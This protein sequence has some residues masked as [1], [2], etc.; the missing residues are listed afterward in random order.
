MRWVYLSPHL[1]DAVFSCGGLI[2]QQ[3]RRGEAIEIWTLCAGD[4]PDERLSLF[5]QELHLRWGS[6]SQPT[7]QRRIEDVTACQIVKATPR[8]FPIPDAI[9]RRAGLNY[10]QSLGQ[11]PASSPPEFQYSDRDS[12]FGDLHP[13][14]DDLIETTA[15]RLKSEA[16]ANT[17]LVCP[18][19]VGG[20]VDHRLT[21][22]VARKITRRLW[23]YA[24]YPYAGEF[25][26][27]IAPTIPAGW[28]KMVFALSDADFDTWI[29]SM[30]A[31]QSQISSFWGNL[32]DMRAALQLY[33][34][35]LG[36]AALW[37][38]A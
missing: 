30:S 17:R 5:A 34:H 37:R 32:E 2:A 24:D 20:H 21:I 9:Y 28:R 26:D 13:A 14:D 25:F 29:E 1:D 3:A 7:T 22:A 12:I 6:A 35:K 31:Y 23:Y 16:Y 8:H 18:L 4:P 15:A 38:P 36:G 27:Q 11:E 19:G 10:W 33:I